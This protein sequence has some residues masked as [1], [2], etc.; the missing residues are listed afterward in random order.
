MLAYRKPNPQQRKKG[1]HSQASPGQET[2][3]NGAR[4]SSNPRDA[5]METE[6]HRINK[7]TETAEV[8][9]N[10]QQQKQEM[11]PQSSPRSRDRKE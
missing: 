11:E 1:W 8:S 10:K 3:S 2:A 9:P 7:G 5:S 6:K 4:D